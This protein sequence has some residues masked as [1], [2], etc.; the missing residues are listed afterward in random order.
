[1]TVSSLPRARRTDITS[2]IDALGVGSPL[3]TGSFRF[4]LVTGEWWCS[5]EVFLMHG[6]EPGA[7]ELGLDELRS[8]KHPDDRGRVLREATA[9][10]RAGRS[11]ACAHR[12]VD[13]KGR[14]RTLA[15]TGEP[16]RDRRGR[17]LALNGTV[18][19]LTH[20]RREIVDREATRVLTAARASVGAT[21]RAKGA[22]MALE[23]IDDRQA[24]ARLADYASRSGVEVRDVA[25]TLLELV[26]RNPEGAKDA[27]FL[28]KKLSHIVG[29]AANR[30]RSAQ[31][32]RRRRSTSAAA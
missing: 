25:N 7:T 26:R 14:V 29:A 20:L 2:V 11:F 5:D 21:E 24:S 3:L 1:M 17:V 19:D 23:G 10:L 16:E 22:L 6:V 18:T 12:I 13:A 32:A 9:A 8:R 15:V 30:Q 27:T 31:L 28:D 4:D